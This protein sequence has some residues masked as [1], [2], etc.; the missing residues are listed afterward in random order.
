MNGLLVILIPATVQVKSDTCALRL[1]P[2]FGRTDHII[3]HITKHQV[4]V[5]CVFAC[6]ICRCT[7]LLATNCVCYMYST[8]IMMIFLWKKNTSSDEKIKLDQGGESPLTVWH[9]SPTWIGAIWGPI[10][11]FCSC[12]EGRLS[13]GCTEHHNTLIVVSIVC[14]RAYVHQS[15]N[16]ATYN[17]YYVCM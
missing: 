8:Y 16:P 10:A 9:Q 17:F 14:I 5:N 13:D 1:V 12:S 15:H 7:R 3:S 11:L 6:M 2:C 4:K